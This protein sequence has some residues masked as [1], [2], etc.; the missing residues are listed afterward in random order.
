MKV[1]LAAILFN[2]SERH[3]A[4]AV[5]VV[6]EGLLEFFDGLGLC[7]PDIREKGLWVLQGWWKMVRKA[8]N[9]NME[10]A[11]EASPAVTVKHG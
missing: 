6:C 1:G 5:E 3:G 7:L 11:V 4:G 9:K 8:V 10:V 2:A